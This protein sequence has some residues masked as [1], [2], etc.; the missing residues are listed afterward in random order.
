MAI[1]KAQL[2]KSKQEWVKKG[3]RP[4]TMRASAA[5]PNVIAQKRYKARIDR[6]VE[7]M[8]QEAEKQYMRLFKSEEANQFFAEDASL[9]SQA[10]ILSNKLTKRFEKLFAQQALPITEQLTTRRASH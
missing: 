6:L 9:G 5:Q 4:A 8:I 3:N 7:Y 2:T 10:R 1:K